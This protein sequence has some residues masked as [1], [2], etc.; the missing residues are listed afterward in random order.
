MLRSVAAAAEPTI[1]R[2]TIPNRVEAGRILK[3]LD[4]PDW[5]LAHSAAVA[6][7]AAF[8]GDAI[9]KRGHAINVPLVEAA[10]LLHDLGK[11]LPKDAPL[12]ALG[13][14]DAAAHY[15]SDI[16]HGELADAVAGHPVTKLADDEHY[17]IWSRSATV[18]ERIVAYADKRAKSDLVP[19]Q[20]R[21]GYWI[22]KHGDTDFMRVAFERAEILEKDVC[23]AAGL[24]PADVQRLRWAEAALDEAG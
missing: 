14:A 11:A 24:D 9:E 17:A 8:L 3:D 19:M 10:A 1:R 12:G 18:E 5:L 21:F 7:V 22:D 23:A 13:H 2:M 6:D 4:P 16:G 20:E 15:L